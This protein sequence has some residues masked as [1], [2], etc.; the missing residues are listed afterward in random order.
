MNRCRVWASCQWVCSMVLMPPAIWP[1]TGDR[2]NGKVQQFLASQPLVSP[3][4]PYLG[5]F[6]C[7]RAGVASG[8]CK[9]QAGREHKAGAGKLRLS[10]LET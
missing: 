10:L 3:H 9:P 1:E 2:K 8:S 7:L 5:A 4:C 6:P